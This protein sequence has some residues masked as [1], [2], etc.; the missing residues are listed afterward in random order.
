MLLASVIDTKVVHYQDELDWAP[1]VSPK[2]W[3]GGRLEIARRVEPFA[4]QV[5]RELA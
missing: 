2:A 3:R 4:E 1:L 5:V